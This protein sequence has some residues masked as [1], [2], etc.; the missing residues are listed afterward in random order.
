MRLLTPRLGLLILFPLVAG[1]GQRTGQVTGKV[2]YKGAP[3]PAGW[4]SF[5]PADSSK[6]A[7]PVELDAEGNFS[8]NLPAGEVTV[9]IDNREWAPRPA[10]YGGVPPGL[11]NLSPE[12]KGKIGAP[13]MPRE[14][15]TRPGRPGKYVRI[16]D[17]YY[18]AET[19]SLK[20]TVEGGS[21][22]KNFELTD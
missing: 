11:P 9:T 19:S 7:V 1:C 14:G 21:Q 13:R 17:K 6:N 3:V 15:E 16:P 5:R 20:F 10:G 12:A 18:E 22:T 8:V 2:T 4:I